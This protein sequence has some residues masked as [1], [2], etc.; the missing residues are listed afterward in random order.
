M[1]DTSPSTESV[2]ATL[3]RLLVA[4]AGLGLGAYLVINHGWSDV[5]RALRAVG[6]PGLAGITLFHALPT[7]LCGLAWWSL[8][9]PHLKED[10]FLFAW[11]RWIRDGTDG[12]VPILPVSGELIA[13]RILRLR[14]TAFAGSGVVVD[15]TAELLGQLLFATLG[16]ALLI[17]THPAAPHLTWIAAGLA[18]MTVQFGGFL[19]AQKKGLFRLIERPLDWLRRRRGRK[20]PEPESEAERTLHDHIIQLHADHEAFLTSIAVHLVAWVVG[21]LEAWIGLW[22]MGHPLGISDVLVMESLVSATRS[23]IFFVPLAAGVQEGAYV[24]IGALVG[25]PGGLALA[26]SL[27]KRARD[28]I[29]GVPAVLLWQLIERRAAHRAPGLR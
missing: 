7:L 20:E 19:I 6:W 5:L 22:L 8:L 4:L 2:H 18:V 3:A 23:V 26:V 25:L 16:F 1:S 11:L 13:T 9:R 21:A 29:K 24:L 17:A 27:I 10:W 15:V 14:G 28:L 12:V